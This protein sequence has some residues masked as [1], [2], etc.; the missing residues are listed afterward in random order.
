MYSIKSAA[1]TVNLQLGCVCFTFSTHLPTFITSLTL[2]PL[3]SLHHVSSPTPPHL[4]LT[5]IIPPLLF[6]PTLFTISLTLS[7]PPPPTHLTRL[8]AHSL[9]LTLLLLSRSPSIS[10]LTPFS[11]TTTTTSAPKRR[12]IG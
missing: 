3:S 12:L 2:Q 11:L 1:N 8:I 6:P 7:Y 4:H 9:S 10:S 5:S